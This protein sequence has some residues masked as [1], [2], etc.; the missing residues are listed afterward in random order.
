MNAY[1]KINN[2]LK[3]Y[4]ELYYK[5]KEKSNFYKEQYESLRKNPEESEWF[6][7]NSNSNNY[8]DKILIDEIIS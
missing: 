7:T 1:E 6:N 2:K 5:E 3:N 8:D 4:N